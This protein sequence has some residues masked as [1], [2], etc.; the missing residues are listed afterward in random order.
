[1]AIMHIIC[2]ACLTQFT[3]FSRQTVFTIMSNS[4]CILE[5]VSRAEKHKAVVFSSIS[6]LQ[7]KCITFP[8]TLSY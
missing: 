6:I 4:W 2:I 7:R 1:M 8:S 5:I 3:F